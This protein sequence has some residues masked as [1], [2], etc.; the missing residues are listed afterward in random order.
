LQNGSV[1][2]VQSTVRAE[3]MQRRVT[4]RECPGVVVREKW[5]VAGEASVQV[6]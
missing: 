1:V 4:V 6:V 3:G 2:D 5:Y